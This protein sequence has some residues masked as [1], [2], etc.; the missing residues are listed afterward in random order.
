M[1]ATAGVLPRF[2]DRVMRLMES[3]EHR[4]ATTDSERDAVFRLRYEAY[5][6]NGLMEPRLDRKLFDERYDNADN[7][8]TAMN[9][10]DGELAGSVRVTVGAGAEADL[11]CVRVYP[12]VAKPRLSSGATAVEYTRLSAKLSL[13]SAFP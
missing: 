1:N 7:A 3:V 13:S 9:F 4:I 11:P 12:D 6:R 2:S 8:W 5:V 10:V